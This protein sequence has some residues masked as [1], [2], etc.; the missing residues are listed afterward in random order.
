MSWYDYLNNQ[1]CYAKLPFEFNGTTALCMYVNKIIKFLIQYYTVQPP[2]E[3]HL[4]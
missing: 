2:E 1:W 4:Y 3:I